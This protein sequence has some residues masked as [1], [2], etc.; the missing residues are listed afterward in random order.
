MIQQDEL[1][2]WIKTQLETRGVGARSRLAEFLN[3][4]PAQLNHMLKTS[5]KA[6]AIYIDEWVKT[7]LFFGIEQTNPN[8]PP[9]II[10]KGKA[11]LAS[12]ASPADKADNHAIVA[13][14]F[15]NAAPKQQA[16][17]LKLVR[18][19]IEEP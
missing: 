17:I 8:L 10:R 12:P 14:I 5:G 11:I 13:K 6:R 1:R 15:G 18:A 19:F 9:V 4:K 7:L 2:Y 16:R 3:L